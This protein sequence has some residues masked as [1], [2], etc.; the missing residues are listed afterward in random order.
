MRL[1]PVQKTVL[2]NLTATSKTTSAELAAVLGSY[3][4]PIARCAYSLSE[5]GLLKAVDKGGKV[6]FSRT[7]A[8]SKALKDAEKKAKNGK[9]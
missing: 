3:P 2:S 8:G 9:K 6:I 7:A 4:G 5:Q 1:T